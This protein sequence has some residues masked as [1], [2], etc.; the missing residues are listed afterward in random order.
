MKKIF[1]LFFLSL[2]TSNAYCCDCVE[3]PSIEKNWEI[4]QQVFIGK[5]IKVDSLLYDDYGGKLYSFTVKIK[6]S[7]KGEI[8]PNRDYRTILY[9]DEAACDFRFGVGYEYL[10]YAG[11]EGYVLN[12]SI[13]SRTDLLENVAKE[14]LITL[15]DIQKEDSKDKQKIRVFK[16]QNNIG[17]QIDLVKNSFEESL[18]RKNLKI[19][20]LFGITIFLLIIILIL[21][22]KRRKRII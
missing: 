9:I 11:R 7:F 8:Y 2:I 12:C 6:K 4:A 15:D 1:L 20:V 5:V 19:Y 21:L 13:C 17:Y 14:E 16:L 10:I 3:K 22:I 18:R